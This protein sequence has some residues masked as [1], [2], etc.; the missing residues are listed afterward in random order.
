MAAAYGQLGDRE[1][2][3]IP[4]RAA[5]AQTRLRHEP[6]REIE[7]FVSPDLV[8]HVMEGLRKVGLEIRMIRASPIPH[9]LPQPL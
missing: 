3:E 5:S 6:A 8:E 4:A 2:R 1:G 9:G 7:K